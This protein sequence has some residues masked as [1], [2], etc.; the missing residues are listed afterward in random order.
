MLVALLAYSGQASAAAPTPPP[1]PE[2]P[3]RFTS[4]TVDITMYEWWLAAWVDNTVYCSFY[5][6]HPG[7]PYGSEISSACGDTLYQEWKANSTPCAERDSRACPGFYFI[8]VSNKPAKRDVTVK[9]PPPIVEVSVQNCDP[10]ETGWCTQQPN[11]VL[12]GKE[13]LPNES[14]TSLA[15]F[16]GTDPFTCKGNT[17]IFQLSPTDLT[18]IRLTFWA[19]STYGDSS[20]IFDAL[21]RVVGETP[22]GERLTPRWYVDVIST[23]W[24]GAPLAS[25]AAAWE[26]FP[27]TDGL[28]QWLTTPETSHGLK[29]SIPYDYL[30]ANLI[31]RGVTDVSSC[32]GLGLNPDG[33]ANACG[34]K[35][36]SSDVRKWQNRFDELIFSV[37]KEGDV[38]AQLLKNLFSRESQFWPGVFRDGKDVGLGQMTEGGADTALLWNPSFYDQFCPLVLNE[39]LCKAKGFASLSAGQ[40]A[41]LRGALVGSVD[42]RCADCPLG[43]DLSRADF[44]VGIFAH[45]L[46]ANCEQAGKIVQ[47]VTN[48]MPGRSVDYETLWRFTLVNYNAGPGC[49]S[50]AVTAAYNQSGGGKLA[51]DDVA[52]MLETSC[53]GA[54]K[55]V[56]DISRNA[57]P[58]PP[59]PSLIQAPG[60]TP[61]PTFDPNLSPTPEATCDPNLDP[62][63]APACDPNLDPACVPACDP[64]L[65]PTCVLDGTPTPEP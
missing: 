8:Q 7:L 11:L 30:A 23:Q 27:P 29:S 36:A 5:V 18:G 25:C 21:L 10:D 53:P 32:P 28:P 45:T 24:T 40:Q 16:A 33:S 15:G 46:L 63:C 31:S 34:L 17:C 49:L 50:D 1:Q 48:E 60:P 22:K 35:A 57:E 56:A 3:D 39:G 6:D 59:A 4:M 51:W 20:K 13:P 61:Q 38:P 65:D 41:L 43:L 58:P 9:L 42:A 12:T 54:A 55:Y 2:G 37:A 19:F 44:S 52:A 14:I 64:L 62:S 26:A 47:N